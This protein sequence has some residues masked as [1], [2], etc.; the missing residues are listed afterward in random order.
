MGSGAQK[1]GNER[2]ISHQ[3]NF[4]HKSVIF[5]NFISM[6]SRIYLLAFVFAA[7]LA[8]DSIP[9]IAQNGHGN[10]K[11]KTYKKRYYKTSTPAP[12]QE[13]ADKTATD[14]KKH[15]DPDEAD[16]S[17]T[18]KQDKDNKDNYSH[19]DRVR[20]KDIKKRAHKEK[21]SRYSEV[22]SSRIGK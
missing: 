5:P 22:Q 7:M 15:E 11:E 20:R 8:A 6:K 19:T 1:T 4:A 12:E 21:W 2:K 16:D 9:A 13:D 14:S 3:Q 18:D 10:R 17:G